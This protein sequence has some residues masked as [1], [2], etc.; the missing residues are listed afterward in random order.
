MALLDIK[1]NQILSF[2]TGIIDEK[3]KFIILLFITFRN[4]RCLFLFPLPLFSRSLNK[5][6]RVK[7][8]INIGLFRNFLYDSFRFLKNNLIQKA[9]LRTVLSLK[10]GLPINNSYI[11]EE[12]LP[13][14]FNLLLLE[15]KLILFLYPFRQP[16]L[17]GH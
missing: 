7:P 9:H 5:L 2:R 4:F 11:V 8:I 3:P 1:P 12:F 14:L 16:T 13:A 15:L 17:I 10:F 6:L